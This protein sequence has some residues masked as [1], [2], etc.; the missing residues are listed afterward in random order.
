MNVYLVVSEGDHFYVEAVSFM[1]AVHNI[2]LYFNEDVDGI[3][4]VDESIIE[5]VT[6]VSNNRVIR[7]S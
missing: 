5:S 4:T 7:E 3:D 2:V 1:E 6:L